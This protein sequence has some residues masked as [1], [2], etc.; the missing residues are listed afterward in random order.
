[1]KFIKTISAATATAALASISI[2]GREAHADTP[3]T[4]NTHAYIDD[5][6]S[7]ADNALA[8]SSQAT[9]ISLNDA[10]EK[11]ETDALTEAKRRKG[12]ALR[13][14]IARPVTNQPVQ[15]EIITTGMPAWVTAINWAQ[16]RLGVQYVW[17]GESDAEGGYDC[18]GL[19]MAAYAQAGI[20]LPRVANDQYNASSVHPG[21]NGLR[22]GDLVFFGPPGS[23]RGIHHVGL[24]VGGGM[25]LHSPNPHSVVRFDRVDYMSD[26]YGATRVT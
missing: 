9:Q 3:T 23:S 25:M 4:P 13:A 22:P 12:E 14:A 8:I 26:Y 24:Y 2:M 5:M 7:A 19:M 15:Q 1:M 17:G 11:A 18:S 10:R 21:R 6:L 20:R 16:T